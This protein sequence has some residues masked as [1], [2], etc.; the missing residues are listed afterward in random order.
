M[1]ATSVDPD[2]NNAV[3]AD[4]AD[5]VIICCRDARNDAGDRRGFD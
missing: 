1:L 5:E 3:V 2:D 4:D